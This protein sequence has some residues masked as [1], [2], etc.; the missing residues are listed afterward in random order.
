[1]VADLQTP[2]YKSNRTSRQIAKHI[3]P[4]KLGDLELA[5]LQVL[6][7]IYEAKLK[8]IYYIEAKLKAFYETAVEGVWQAVIDTKVNHNTSLVARKEGGAQSVYNMIENAE[9]KKLKLIEQQ[10][11]SKKSKNTLERI[12]TRS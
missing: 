2:Y 7:S 9:H 1:M 6:L 8:V 4:R 12:S 10:L 11:K 5:R 3:P